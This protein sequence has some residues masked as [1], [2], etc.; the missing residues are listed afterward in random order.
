MGFSIANVLKQNIVPLIGKPLINSISASLSM[1]VTGYENYQFLK[2]RGIPCVIVFWHGQQFYPIYY[3]RNRKIA[4][5]VSLSQDGEMQNRILTSFGYSVVRGSSS[6]GAVSGLI[7]LIRKMR[8]GHDVAIALDGPRGPYHSAKEGVNYIA[9]KENCYVLPIACG[10]VSCRQFAA[11]DKYILPYPMTK[12]LMMIGRP[13]LPNALNLPMMTHKYLE[14]ILNSMTDEIET[15]LHAENPEMKKVIRVPS[16]T[17]AEMVYET[18]ENEQ[19]I[20]NDIKDNK[21]DNELIE[22]K[23]AGKDDGK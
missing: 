6:R 7:G 21:N 5:M 18:A 9:I 11:W 20:E 2:E 19:V 16:G 1:K 15:T 13:F 4:I 17:E 22:N 14:K 23:D 8:E 10:F 3:F 12:G